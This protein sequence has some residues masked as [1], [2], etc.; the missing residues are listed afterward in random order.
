MMEWIQISMSTAT[1]IALG[2]GLWRCGG[3]VKQIEM[4]FQQIEMRF[5][6]LEKRMDKF[7]MRLDR[8]EQDVIEIKIKL[9]KY[10]N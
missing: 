1:I 4:K 9:S 10:F 6:S 5:D 2:V 8:L 7:E 3:F